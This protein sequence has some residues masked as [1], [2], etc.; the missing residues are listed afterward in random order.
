MMSYSAERAFIIF[1]G[2]HGKYKCFFKINKTPIKW[3]AIFPINSNLPLYLK[4]N[5]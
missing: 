2:K 3:L 5:W 1:W 4:E